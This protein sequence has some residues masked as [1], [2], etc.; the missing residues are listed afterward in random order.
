MISLENYY[1]FFLACII[2]NIKKKKLKYFYCLKF[3]LVLFSKQL[4]NLKDQIE[5][6]IENISTPLL[7]CFHDN[8]SNIYGTKD[9]KLIKHI[10]ILILKKLFLQTNHCT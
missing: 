9:L 7:V 5:L 2:E 10:I 8:L 4:I 3:P 6:P 1:M